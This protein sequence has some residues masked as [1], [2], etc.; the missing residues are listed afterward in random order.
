MALT[1]SNEEE[2][3]ADGSVSQYDLPS[4]WVGDASSA[5]QAC[6]PVLQRSNAT[7]GSRQPSHHDATLIHSGP[8][9]EN[10]RKIQLTVSN[11]DQQR[12]NGTGQR[13]T[14][15]HSGKAETNARA[16]DAKVAVQTCGEMGRPRDVGER[17]I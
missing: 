13:G 12:S 8:V 6:K 9:Y 17:S 1:P 16:A 15:Q 11:G 2:T 3:L 5:L 4:S 7:K 14:F 10:T